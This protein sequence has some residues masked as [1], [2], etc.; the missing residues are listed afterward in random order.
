MQELEYE[1]KNM[2]FH[3]TPLILGYLWKN[4]EKIFTL[5]LEKVWVEE[6]KKKI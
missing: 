5:N 3:S 1:V 4:T 6:K 2:G